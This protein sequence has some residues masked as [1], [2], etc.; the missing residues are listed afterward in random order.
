[1][2][3]W[4]FLTIT[5]G[6]TLSTLSR[7]A[8]AIAACC[9]TPVAISADLQTVVDQLIKPIMKEY[10]V[11]GI[12]VA[13]TVNGKPAYFSYG[14][15]SKE[16]SAPVD[17]NTLFELGSVSKTFTATMASYALVQGKLSLDD[18]PSRYIPKLKGSALDKATVLHFG[19]YTAGG[20]PLQFPDDLADNEQGMLDY[21]GHFKP[22][23]GPGVVRQYSNPSLGMFGNLAGLALKSDPAAV[24]EKQILPGLGMHSTYIRMPDSALAHYAWGYNQKNQPV[25]MGSELFS[26]YTYG[27]RSSTADMIRYVQANIDPSHLDA[28]LSRAIK[29]THVGYFQVGGMTQGLGWEQYAYPV[30]LDTLQAGNSNTMSRLANPVKLLT[31]A[32]PAS[33]STWYNKT[34]ATNGF[35]AYVAFVPAKKIGIVILANKNY[36]IEARVKAAYAIMQQLEN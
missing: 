2:C 27:V 6:I 20:L 13:V 22:K 7:L 9:S 33:D 31:P 17:E 19:T 14:V 23:A 16:S 29:G 18:H 24:L 35:G 8:L 3:V 12:A 15:A 4:A 34:G 32:K 10:D 28:T 5:K 11:P 1:M 25:R 30:A 21:F 36:P 26:G